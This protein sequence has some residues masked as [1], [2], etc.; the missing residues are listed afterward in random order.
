METVIAGV[1]WTYLI[2]AAVVGVGAIIRGF[3]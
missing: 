3:L 2:V 1:Q